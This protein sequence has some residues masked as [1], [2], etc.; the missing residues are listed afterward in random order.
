MA[1]DFGLAIGQR[2]RG[3]PIDGARMIA[4]VTVAVGFFLGGLVG[5]LFF[6]ASGFAALWS[7]CVLVALL[8]LTAWCVA[9]RDV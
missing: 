6:Y 4:A 8:A 1:T 5:G 9:P 7:P 3:L 2:L